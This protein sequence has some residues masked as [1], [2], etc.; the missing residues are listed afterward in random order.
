MARNGM[1]SPAEEEARLWQVELHASRDR[2]YQ[3][4]WQ[5]AADAESAVERSRRL[6]RMSR[7]LA[8]HS[9]ELRRESGRLRH[10]Y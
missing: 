7:A 4:A 9:K 10:G 5:P 2:Y 6:I 3:R 8:E 1:L